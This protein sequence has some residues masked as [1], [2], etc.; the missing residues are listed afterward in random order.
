M[1]VAASAARAGAIDS[2]VTSEVEYSTTG[3]I[4]STTGVT[5]A[6]VISFNSVAGGSFLSP[7]SFSLGEFLIASLPVGQTTT[8]VNTPFEIIYH[9][10][11]INGVDLEANETPIKLTGVLN[12]K[13]SGPNQSSVVAS[14]DP[15]PDTEFRTGDFLNTLTL[16]G[17]VLLVPSS[18]N[19]GRTTAQGQIASTYSPVPEPATVTVFLAAIAG[20][21]LRRRLRARTA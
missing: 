1:L 13:V 4:I 8:Y 6:N 9:A 18:N 11:R 17:S 21:G 14:F 2:T 16:T 20:L 7:S 15:L 10:N 19:G 12:G 5:G 3:N